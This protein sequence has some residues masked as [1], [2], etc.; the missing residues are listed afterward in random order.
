[1]EISE[2]FENM[3]SEEFAV[4]LKKKMMKHAVDKL[5]QTQEVLAKFRANRNYKPGE[6]EEADWEAAKAKVGF[7][8]YYRELEELMKDLDINLEDSQIIVTANE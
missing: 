3:K 2:N 7:N 5:L 4:L 8:Y 1:M 6:D